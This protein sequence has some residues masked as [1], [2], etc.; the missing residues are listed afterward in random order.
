[1]ELRRFR[2]KPRASG[3]LEF[4]DDSKRSHRICLDK[5]LPYRGRAKGSVEEKLEMLARDRIAENRKA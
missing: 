1:M 4:L 3:L 2:Q 5:E